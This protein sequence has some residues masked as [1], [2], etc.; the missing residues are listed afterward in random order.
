VKTTLVKSLTCAD[1][2]AAEDAAVL[3]GP[4]FKIN[5]GKGHD[6]H[7]ASGSGVES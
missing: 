5:T 4:A 6:Q 1:A 2:Q 7:K 3:A